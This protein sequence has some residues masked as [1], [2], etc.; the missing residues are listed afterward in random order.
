MVV[1]HK[2]FWSA[3]RPPPSL[4]VCGMYHPKLPPTPPLKREK[5][6]ILSDC[7]REILKPKSLALRLVEIFFSW[8]RTL[9]LFGH[10]YGLVLRVEVLF[11]WTKALIFTVLTLSFWFLSIYIICLYSCTLSSPVHFKVK[12]FPQFNYNIIITAAFIL[13]FYRQMLIAL[14]GKFFN[15]PL[16]QDR[17]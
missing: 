15:Y 12:A 11:G 13:F 7:L 4:P 6:F 10:R 16:R 3:S 8:R 17:L 9:R 14:M 5:S 1:F 2:K